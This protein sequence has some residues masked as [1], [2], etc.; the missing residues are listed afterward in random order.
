LLAFVVA[1]G[2]FGGGG[3]SIM[4]GGVSGTAILIEHRRLKQGRRRSSSSYAAEGP[5]LAA[6]RPFGFEK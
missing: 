2:R 6:A 5:R 1:V 4:S 3:M